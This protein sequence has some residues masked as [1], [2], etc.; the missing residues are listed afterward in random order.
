MKTVFSS[1]DAPLLIVF[2][3]SNAHAHATRLPE[4]EIIRTPLKNVFG[5]SREF[6]QSYDLDGVTWSGFT[7]AGMNLGETQDDT[8]CLANLFA[9]KWQNAIDSGEELP[10][11]YVIQISVGSQ[12]VAQFEANRQN[13]WYPMREPV[14]KPGPL[15]VCD[16]SLYPLAVSILSLAMIDLIA[17]GKHPRV[18]GLHWNQWETEASTGSKALNEAEANYRNLFWGFFTA[19]GS[20]DTGSRIP[21]YLYRPLCELFPADRLERLSSLFDRFADILSDCRVL[22]LRK[23]PL[24]TDAPMSHGIFQK[25]NGHYTPEAHRWFAERQW[26]DL[27]GEN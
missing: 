26:Q 12:G 17:S 6:N 7:T 5:L 21:L 23:S 18:I 9:A 15:G 19:L 11:L 27:F 3:Q 24:W 14:L 2:G 4:S 13:M 16:I 8:C 22:D 1:S 20:D 25:D 10:G